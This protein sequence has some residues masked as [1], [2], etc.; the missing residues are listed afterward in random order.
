[1]KSPCSCDEQTH[2]WCSHPNI[3]KSLVSSPEPV[4][5][6]TSPPSYDGP[7]TENAFLSFEPVSVD[8]IST[9]LKNINTWKAS[10]S[11]GIP[12]FVLRQNHQYLASSLAAVINESLLTGVFPS[13]FKLARVCPV[14]KKGDRTEPGNYRPIS[15][16]PVVSKILERVV[17]Q[18]LVQYLQSQPGLLP[19]EQ[20][21]YRQCHSCE[22][23]LC[24]CID[25]WQRSLDDGKSVADAFLDLSK[26]FDC[27]NHS[28]LVAELFNCGLG[29]TVLAWFRS[30]LSGRTQ[31][32]VCPQLPP[33]ETY[34]STRGVP[35]GS[36]LGPVL[37]SLY[38]RSLPGC[39]KS[40]TT[41]LYADETALYE[42][43]KNPETALTSLEDDI[44]LV[45]QYFKS[46]GLTLNATKTQFLH[47]RTPATPCTRP[48]HVLGVAIPAI[49]QAK[50]LG[51][52]I[53]DHL[54]FKGQV[55]A[56]RQKVGAKLSTFYR[57]RGQLT[58]RA[59]RTFYLS[60]I[61]STLEYGSNAYVH[62]LHAAQYN[63]LVKLGKRALRA[64][65]G[66]P[67]DA[68]TAPI[69]ARFS[70]MLISARYNLKLYTVVFR[71]IAGQESSLLSSLF[72]LRSTVT[73]PQ[74][75]QT[76]L[77]CS[78]GLVLP[79]PVSRYGRVSLSYLA[80]DRWN[81]APPDLRSA[82]S[83]ATFH[84]ALLN[85]LGYPVRRP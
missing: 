51:L 16:L 83:R 7:H 5:F 22:D 21:A 72:I 76:R 63:A 29:E 17:Y 81:S 10:G 26:A 50:Y 69:L 11:D 4:S 14:F 79:R 78:N 49:S 37:F 42:A 68:H 53:D 85:H 77:Q 1:M 55:A 52:V 75:R 45:H 67:R 65:F 84:R 43:D 54:S 32:V 46:K 58:T 38:T 30:Y 60:F 33:G 39:V 3:T 82:V 70:L 47:I 9:M 62:C 61:Q 34:S 19:A 66:Y 15:L 73:G 40:T 18:Q 24:L 2:V 36:V 6:H 27:V 48:L 23:A 13:P 41:Q 35:Q 59:K 56:L 71:C 64:V 31:Q 20:F 74:Q 57:V 8:S 80:A 12:P 28:Y 44:L 25:S